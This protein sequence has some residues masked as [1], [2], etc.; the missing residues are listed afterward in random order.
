MFLLILSFVNVL[1]FGRGKP[2]LKPNIYRYLN[3]HGFS[4]EQVSNDFSIIGQVCL[5]I[6]I[7]SLQQNVTYYRKPIP[8]YPGQFG[9]ATRH[10]KLSRGIQ[11][12]VGIFW[13]CLWGGNHHEELFP[14]LFSCW[15]HYSAAF[16]QIHLLLT[17]TEKGGGNA[18][19]R[20]CLRKEN[21]IV[22]GSPVQII[23]HDVKTL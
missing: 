19:L 7:Y 15:Y 17:Y 4:R 11:G 2:N 20:E 22:R 21:G 9:L 16:S 10:R 23:P 12:W 6:P 3:I 1:S 5:V 18:S 13:K 14:L 8:S